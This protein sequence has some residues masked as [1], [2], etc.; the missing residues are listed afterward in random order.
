[1]ATFNLLVVILSQQLINGK[2]YSKWK[3]NL[4]I[5]LEYEKIKFVFTTPKPKEPTIDAQKANISVYC[6]ILI[7]VASHLQEQISKLESGVK[8]F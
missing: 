6:Y 5:I 2:N 1:M 7:N 3:I 8:M 4:Y